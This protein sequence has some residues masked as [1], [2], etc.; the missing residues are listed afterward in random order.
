[1]KSGAVGHADTR[2]APERRRPRPE[3]AVR[4]DQP[5]AALG[6]GRPQLRAPGQ[7][8]L[9]R[10]ARRRVHPA[11]AARPTR[12]ARCPRYGVGITNI[13][14]RP[15]RAADELSREELR[16]GARELDALVAADPAA[17]W[18]PSS[19]S[20]PTGP[21]S[22]A[23][24]R[25]WA[26][27]T[28]THR[29]PRP[30]LD[31]PQPERPQRP[32]QARRLRPPLRRGPP[33]KPSSMALHARSCRRCR[34]AVIDGTRRRRSPRRRRPRSARPT[35]DGTSVRTSRGVRSVTRST[36]APHTP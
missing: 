19:A 25:R 10:A 9:P 1:M 15:T 21:R 35:A 6:R 34:W 3:G 33:E 16:A 26:C 7:P 29:R 30:C 4:R 12:T 31:P 32:L 36:S 8:L 11:A 24:R 23:R 2:A 5:V 13:A 14:S 17:R 28:E 27:R 18:S 22:S 20:P